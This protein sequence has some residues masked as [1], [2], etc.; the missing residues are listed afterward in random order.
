L[1]G[2]IPWFA[3]SATLDSQT[4]ES[5]RTG[6]SFETDVKVQRT[7][8]DR[9][10]LLFRIGW[11]PKGARF[12]ALQF[13]FTAD[14][15][16]VESVYQPLSKIPKTIIFFNS[17]KG[18]H[19]AAA[20]CCNW[21]LEIRPQHYTLRQVRQALRIFHRN[22]GST[23]KKAILTEFVK[24][25]IQSRIRVIFATEALGMGVDIPD[26]RRTVQWDIPIGEHA[27]TQLQRGGRASRDKLDGEMIMLLPDWASGE[28]SS[29]SKPMRNQNKGQ[30]SVADASNADLEA[31]QEVQ[32]A[33]RVAGKQRR[34]DL[35]DFWY[36]LANERKD[37]PLCLRRQFLDFFNELNEHRSGRRPDRCCSN[38]NPQTR[39]GNLDGFYQYQEHGPR[40]NDRTKAVSDALDKW[41]EEQALLV[42]QDCVFLPKSTFFLSSDLREKLAK[43]AHSVL[44]IKS[45][46]RLLGSWRWS[47]SHEQALFNIVWHSYR[48]VNAETPSTQPSQPQLPGLSS[49]S[50]LTISTFDLST[51]ASV[52]TPP[53]ESRRNWDLALSLVSTPLTLDMSM[54][55]QNSGPETWNRE[56]NRPLRVRPTT[57]KRPA[58]EPISGNLRARKA[59]TRDIKE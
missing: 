24:E 20:E 40:A 50:T 52:S 16:N 18:A 38:C 46:R 27:A 34:D 28:R 47:H 17:R 56:T 43:N 21:L 25:G 5:L 19:T 11:I 15:E 48:P 2:Q 37:P 14:E 49:Q 22:T 1:G 26:I 33:K 8:I 55:S 58:L 54:Q 45:L 3:C 9:P 10:E 51:P 35:S 6:I 32:K 23:D 13:L 31:G 41:A 44:C 30:I 53:Q 36:D 42:Y 59:C 7:S 29:G 4:L 39:L 57:L 12:K